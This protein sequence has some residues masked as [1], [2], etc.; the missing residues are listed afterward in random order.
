M[1]CA[2]YVVPYDVSRWS[3]TLSIPGITYCRQCC[4]LL[5]MNFNVQLHVSWTALFCFSCLIFYDVF[6]DKGEFGCDYENICSS[7]QRVQE[8]VRIRFILA[9]RRNWIMKMSLN[10]KV[11]CC[12][13][14]SMKLSFVNY[15][16]RLFFTFAFVHRSVFNTDLL[17]P[18]KSAK[19]HEISRKFE[20]IAVQGH[21]RSSILVPMENAYASFY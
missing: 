4:Y 6:A 9:W 8:S 10:C 13:I 20:L 12:C 7:S 18:P 14:C 19:S 5:A 2:A 11:C 21:P 16:S 15:Y 1:S 17:L 3:A